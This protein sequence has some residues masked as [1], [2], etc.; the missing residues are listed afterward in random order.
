[1]MQEVKFPSKRLMVTLLLIS[2]PIILLQNFYNPD[3]VTFWGNSLCALSG[4]L[5]AFLYFIPS[6]II[7]KRT[8]GDFISFAEIKTPSAILFVSSYYSLYFVYVSEYFLLKYTDMFSKKINPDANIYVVTF[9]LLALCLYASCKGINTISRCGLF[10]FVL[11]LISFAV[12]FSGNISNLDFSQNKFIL[13]D[14]YNGF[15]NNASYFMITAVIAVIF[16]CVSSQTE[17]FKTRHILVTL[18][19]ILVFFVLTMFFTHFSLGLYGTRQ[20]YQTFVLS[21]AAHFFSAFGMDSFFLASSAFL[22]FMLL[23]VLLFSISKTMNKACNVK[24]NLLFSLII[25]ILFICSK[26]FNSVREILL[27]TYVLNALTFIS[28]VLIPTIYLIVFRRKKSD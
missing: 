12:I 8:G 17:K 11:V 27:D 3:E 24:I 7:R 16:S 14:G 18:A 22:I 15:F 10:V 20:E 5:I 1:M 25:F 13:F 2:L 9:L 19:S 6:V 21:K 23:S 26:Q 4:V 28:A